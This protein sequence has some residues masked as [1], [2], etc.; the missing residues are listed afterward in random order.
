MMDSM[1][2]MMREWCSDGDTRSLDDDWM[3]KMMQQCC[4]G[5][6]ASDCCEMSRDTRG[7]GKD[8]V[9]GTA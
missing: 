8:E 6:D 7:A 3:R 9:D 2:A 1:F 5:C 4:D